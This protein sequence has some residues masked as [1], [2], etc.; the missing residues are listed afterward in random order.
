MIFLTVTEYISV[1][2]SF[3]LVNIYLLLS[4]LITAA[5]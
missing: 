4:L 1:K 2:E 3:S 5:C